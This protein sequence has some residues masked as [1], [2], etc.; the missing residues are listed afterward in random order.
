MVLIDPGGIG[1]RSSSGCI[2]LFPEDVAALYH[3]VSLGTAVRIIHSPYKF[4]YHQ[5]KLYI[6]AHEP[7]S[8]PYYQSEPAE[9]VVAQALEEAL[10]DPMILDR[11]DTKQV[12]EMSKGYPILITD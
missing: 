12:I 3:S 7:L 6:E 2:R 4:G 10:L 9:L 1:V 8:D 11:I 5:N